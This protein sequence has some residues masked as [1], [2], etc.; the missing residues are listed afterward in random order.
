MYEH[1]NLVLLNQIKN[2]NNL[3]IGENKKLIIIFHF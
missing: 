3:K 1:D 2:N